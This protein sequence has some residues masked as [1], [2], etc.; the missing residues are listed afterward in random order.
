MK[1][2]G[3][4]KLWLMLALHFVSMFVLMYSMV[5]APDEVLFNLNNVY[6]AALMTMPMLV[7]EML[8]MGEMYGGAKVTRW[9][10]VAGIAGL[11]AF[12]VFIRQQTLIGDKE[13]LRSMIP[14]HSGAILMCQRSSIEDAQIKRLCGQI[15]ESQRAEIA[16][17]EEILRRL[18]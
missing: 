13:F 14:H 8:M 12:F 10:M 1:Q 15:V 5:D 3:M 6:M 9:L 2:M 17:M 4:N 16:E 11:I 18:E 7:L